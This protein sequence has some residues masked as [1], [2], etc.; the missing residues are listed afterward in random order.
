MRGARSS[1]VVVLRVIT[2]GLKLG[3]VVRGLL[4]TV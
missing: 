2:R 4:T 3:G 1:S